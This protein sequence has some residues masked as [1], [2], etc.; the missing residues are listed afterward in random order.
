[1][2]QEKPEPGGFDA[3]CFH[4]LSSVLAPGLGS[5]LGCYKVSSAHWG[6]RLGPYMRVFS[7]WLLSLWG[8]HTFFPLL[9]FIKGLVRGKGQVVMGSA[10]S[11]GA[12]GLFFRDA[13]HQAGLCRI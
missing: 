4:S 2:L 13:A 10:A 1:M 11:R 5:G 8:F 12:K 7:L 9:L 3:S 6:S